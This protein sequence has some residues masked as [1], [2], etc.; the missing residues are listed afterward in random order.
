MG[1]GLFN[2]ELDDGAPRDLPCGEDVANHDSVIL[3]MKPDPGA[4]DGKNADC[5]DSGESCL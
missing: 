1:D 3:K 2:G 5:R 4:P